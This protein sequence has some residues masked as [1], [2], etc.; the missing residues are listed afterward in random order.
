MCFLVSFLIVLEV[1]LT[2]LARPNEN[3]VE[4]FENITH[5]NIYPNRLASIFSSETSRYRTNVNTY[6][7]MIMRLERAFSPFSHAWNAILKTAVGFRRRAVAGASG[8]V[9]S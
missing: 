7:S 4:E 3:T 2:V 9:Y 5:G 8:K 1:C 6:Q